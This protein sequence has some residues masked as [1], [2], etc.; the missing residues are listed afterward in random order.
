MFYWTEESIRWYREAAQASHFHR[1]LA[2][3]LCA[4]IDENET[5]CDL[6]CGLGYLSAE[7]AKGCK[8]V[9]AVD[10]DENALAELRQRQP[11][12]VIVLCADAN[13][14][15]DAMHCD[16][17]VLCFFGR[18]TEN[19]NFDRYFAHCT[20]RMI[21]IV[22]GST[23]SAISPTGQ[24]RLTKERPPQICAFL[25]E[26]G[27]PFRLR[28]TELSF[29][30][31]FETQEDAKAFVQY[32]AKSSTPQEVTAHVQAHLVQKNG[33]YLLPYQKK[34]GIFIIEK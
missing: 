4:E 6:G 30:Q 15:P 33:G 27:I 3:M 8:T 25:K 11:K 23:Q 14:L 16:T 29:G 5:V 18:L 32:Y 10:S 20:R 13:T 22:S 7:L 28:E 26:R 34:I 12:N 19:G 9:F 24:S 21:A 17:L 1:D 2:K 31:P